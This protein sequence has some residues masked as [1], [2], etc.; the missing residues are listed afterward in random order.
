M[1]LC[2]AHQVFLGAIQQRKDDSQE[3]TRDVPSRS[4]CVVVAV[5]GTYT[6]ICKCV[7]VVGWS[8]NTHGCMYR[9]YTHT[10]THSCTHART[11]AHTRARTHSYA[12]AFT[13]AHSH[14]RLTSLLS[15][16]SPEQTSILPGGDPD[17]G[18]PA[19]QAQVHGT[20][21]SDPAVTPAAETEGSG[22]YEPIPV[23]DNVDE[24]DNMNN[25]NNDVVTVDV[26]FNEK[27]GE[28]EV[29]GRGEVEEVEGEEVVSGDPDVVSGGV[30]VGDE[31]LTRST[32][33]G[34]PD[35]D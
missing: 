26:P 14:A 3:S 5:A 28:E 29:K 6:C 10:C 9:I 21:R 20:E 11:Y 16:E 17:A 8:L 31:K 1:C 2:L 15:Q 18:M 7:V 32:V 24:M 30:V 23:T 33:D 19:E 12:H 4:E 27:E 25:N 22:Q 35:S 13:H 34:Q